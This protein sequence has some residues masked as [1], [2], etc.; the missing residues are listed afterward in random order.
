MTPEW[1]SG[2]WRRVSIAI[3]GEAPIENA[4]VVWLQAGDAY[5]DLRI[6][7]HDDVAAVS[8]AGETRWDE[9]RL[10]WAHH[11]DLAREESDDVGVLDLQG[12]DLVETGS[13]VADGREVEYVERWRRLSR[14]RPPYLA[15]RR[16]DGLAV[17]VQAGA[18]ALTVADDRD[19]GGEYRACYRM[20]AA[21][22]WRSALLLGANADALPA[23]PDYTGDNRWLALGGQRWR[24]SERLEATQQA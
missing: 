18:H 15:L 1:V 17:V 22:V 13:T 24:V 2:A 14:S 7:R 21:G 6:P 11:L 3:D 9:P 19:T 12:D 5:A 8:F 23:P 20:K 16:E 10:R 4:D